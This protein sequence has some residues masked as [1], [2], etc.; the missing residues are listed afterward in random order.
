MTAL[1]NEYFVV[2]LLVLFCGVLFWAF[3]PKK[4]KKNQMLAGKTSTEDED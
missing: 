4:K 1:L 2:I 3:K